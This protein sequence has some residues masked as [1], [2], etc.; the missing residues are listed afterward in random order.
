MLPE[1]PAL[2]CGILK[3]NYDFLRVQWSGWHPA[4]TVQI[5]VSDFDP[6]TAD[7][8]GVCS[9]TVLQR[10]LQ[11]FCHSTDFLDTFH[12]DFRANLKTWNTLNLQNGWPE[13]YVF[14]KSINHFLQEIIPK[15][16]CKNAYRQKQKQQL[17]PDKV[18]EIRQDLFFFF[19]SGKYIT[20]KFQSKIC[21]SVALLLQDKIVHLYFL[22][23]YLKTSSS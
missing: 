14:K 21:V 10:W 1:T 7:V 5:I 17:W 13:E 6:G 2:F 4:S 9:G 18:C 12:L 20:N 8:F 19:W 23:P 11:N 22:N 16:H 3:W 15:R